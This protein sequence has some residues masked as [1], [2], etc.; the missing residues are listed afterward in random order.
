MKQLDVMHH[1][2]IMILLIVVMFVIGIYV[3]V[4]LVSL[5]TE[6]VLVI[7]FSFLLVQ[8]VLLYIVF[9]QLVHVQD[10]LKRRK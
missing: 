8:S 1:K 7:L 5:G 3:G 10:V 9:T 2:F 6:R 4:R